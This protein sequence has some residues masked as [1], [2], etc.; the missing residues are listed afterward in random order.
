MGVGAVGGGGLFGALAG[1]IA[2]AD[3]AGAAA[4]VTAAIDNIGIFVGPPLFGWIV[5][6][7]GSYSPAWWTM[8][9]AALLAAA[10]LALIR[11]PRRAVH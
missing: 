11:E 3:A 5:D 9:G 1:E 4:G 10:L 6:R 2:G 8:F 7:A